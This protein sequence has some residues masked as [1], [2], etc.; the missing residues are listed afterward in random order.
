MRSEIERNRVYSIEYGHIYFQSLF[1]SIFV[2]ISFDLGSNPTVTALVS[3]ELGT[4][5]K[6]V[7]LN[8]Y[9]NLVRG[10]Q[11]MDKY[12]CTAKNNL[13]KT[14]FADKLGSTVARVR[15]KSPI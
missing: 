13:A 4:E 2:L 15:G 11:A 3:M 12:G 8:K 5:T 1:R 10:R 7:N 14:N 9:E 6:T